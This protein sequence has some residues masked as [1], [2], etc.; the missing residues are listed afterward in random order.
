M[1]FSRARNQARLPRIGEVCHGTVIKHSAIAGDPI[2]RSEIGRCGLSPRNGC[3]LDPKQL[4]AALECDM[5]G[6][7]VDAHEANIADERH[8][9]SL[10]GSEDAVPPRRI[11]NFTLICR[12]VAVEPRLGRAVDVQWSSILPE[13]DRRSDL[14]AEETIVCREVRENTGTPYPFVRRVRPNVRRRSMSRGCRKNRAE[15]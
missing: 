8:L 12:S 9:V 10:V 14:P 2:A 7:L 5:V 3:A 15:R 13:L 11:N 4:I 6:P 1:F